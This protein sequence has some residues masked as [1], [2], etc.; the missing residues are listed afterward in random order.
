MEEDVDPDDAGAEE[1]YASGDE[2]EAETDNLTKGVA[3][4]ELIDGDE[5]GWST[6][7]EG[8]GEANEGSPR[9]NSEGERVPLREVV[10]EVAATNGVHE[11]DVRTRVLT[12]AELED[13]FDST[14]PDLKRE[15]SQIP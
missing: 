13:L 9:R 5:D 10:R 12:V 7:G 3:D 2:V 14:A 8:D 11:E 6:E 15:Y 1:V 4:T